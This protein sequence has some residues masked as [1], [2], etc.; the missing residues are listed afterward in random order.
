M[1]KIE[2]TKVNSY[3]KLFIENIKTNKEKISD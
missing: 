2:N 1:S 3:K